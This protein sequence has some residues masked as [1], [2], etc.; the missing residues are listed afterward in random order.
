MGRTQGVWLTVV[1][2]VVAVLGTWALLSNVTQSWLVIAALAGFGLLMWRPVEVLVFALVVAQE[3][4]DPADFWTSNQWL[5]FGN[6]L[7]FTKVGSVPLVAILVLSAAAIHLVKMR[8]RA[9]SD[10]FW[11]VWI[12]LAIWVLSIGAI[13]SGQTQVVNAFLGSSLQMVPLI[14]FGGWIL[15]RF[16]FR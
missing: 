8:R 13:Q 3:I 11:I 14:L 1:A 10:T 15:N 6:W 12:I 16:N 2:G 9:R 5:V 7:Y 4:K